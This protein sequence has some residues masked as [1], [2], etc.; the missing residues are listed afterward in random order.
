M[1]IRL[2]QSIKLQS[3]LVQIHPV[4]DVTW[5]EVG[6]RQV[7]VHGDMAVEQWLHREA[8]GLQVNEP[9]AFARGFQELNACV[10]HNFNICLEVPSIKFYFNR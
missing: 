10:I 9:N 5:I 8:E 7:G 3:L 4:N 2:S 1:H 6:T